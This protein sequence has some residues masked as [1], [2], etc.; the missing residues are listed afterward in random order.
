[1]NWKKAAAGKQS[2]IINQTKDDKTKSKEASRTINQKFD[3]LRDE[4]QL[5]ESAS[6]KPYKNPEKDW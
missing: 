4:K 6:Q 2:Q 3:E 5:P 1:M